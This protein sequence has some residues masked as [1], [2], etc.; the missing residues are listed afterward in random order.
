[1]NYFFSSDHHFFHTNV[2]KFC[3]RPFKNVEKMNSELILRHNAVVGKEDVVV[4]VGDFSFADKKKTYEEVISKMNGQLIFLRGSHDKWMG[5]RGAGFHEIWEK[6][7]GNYYIVACHYAMASWPRSH[8]NS[9]QLYGHHHG[10]LSFPNKSMDVGVDT[11]NFYPYSLD[12]II[13]IL[14]KKPETSGLIKKVFG[15]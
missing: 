13:E 5:K 10:S 2:L 14:N 4:I 1:M 6:K 3:N 9:Y 7:L 8:Y 12:N 11:N 15:E